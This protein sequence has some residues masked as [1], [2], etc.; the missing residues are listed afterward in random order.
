MVETDEKPGDAPQPNSDQ[1]WLT[2]YLGEHDGELEPGARLSPPKQQSGFKLLLVALVVIALAGAAVFL[3]KS[4]GLQLEANAKPNDLGQGVVAD[5]GLRGHLVTEWKG[6][7]V[8]YQLKVEPIDARSDQGFAKVVATV[9][10]LYVNVRVLDR[11]G[12]PVCGKQV[13]LQAGGGAAK[14]ADAFKAIGG[15]G[16]HAAALWAEGT[17][18]CSP[19]QYA[20]FDYWDFATNFPTIAEQN[21]MLGLPV[22]EVAEQEMTPAPAQPATEPAIVAQAPAPAAPTHRTGRRR[23]VVKKPQSTFYLEGDDRVAAFERGRNVLSLD[24]SKSFVL[25]RPGDV[26]TAAEWED[27]SS[28]VHYTC[29]QHA[30]CTLRHG[31]VLIPARMSY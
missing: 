8:H 6:K 18:P 19:D 20:Q 3:I 7:T 24:G 13:M 31:G 4:K 14:G 15:P 30:S 29:D 11:A 26:A 21:R 22:Q 2:T 28:L 10:P 17:M 27:N 12:A 5:S 9:Q 25:L 1:E 16:G 23:N